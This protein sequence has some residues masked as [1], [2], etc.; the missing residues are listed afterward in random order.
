[1]NLLDTLGAESDLGREVVDT[2]VLEEGRL[3]VGRLNNS[4]TLGSLEEG[5]S[6]A[7]TSL[8]HGE[9]GGTSTVLGLDNLVTTELDTVN[10]GIKSL[11]RDIG[12]TGLGDQ[13]NNGVTRVATD[14]GD[15]LLSRVGSLNLR[16][17]SGGSDD[18][19]SGDTK[20]LLGVVDTLG[21]KDLGN[22]GDSGV[23]GVGDDENLGLRGKLSNTLGK[24]ADNGGVG[25]EKIITGH[26][27]LSG[28]T[29]GDDN[30]LDTG[31][32]LLK[33]TLLG[34]V[35]S[36][37]GVGGNVR[38]IG[39]DT[40]GSSQIVEGKT[41]DILVELKEEGKGL[42]NTTGGTENGNLRGL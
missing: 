30:N 28:N 42:T 7:G 14:N 27:R 26:T 35:A 18:I 13:G 2:L 6:K 5:A 12:V 33:T 38:K 29:S 8:S 31:K 21:L 36:D 1:M 41:S 11:T 4:L 15:G 32:G 10:K 20:D 40:G 17:E 22:N 9:S 23:D 3:N 24:V 16:D 34:G 25:V 39:S 37:L 19:K